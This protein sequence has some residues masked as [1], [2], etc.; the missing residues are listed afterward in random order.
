M[1]TTAERLIVIHIPARRINAAHSHRQPIHILELLL[2][3]I[4]FARIRDFAWQS[5]EAA[6]PAGELIGLVDFMHVSS[7][8][9]LFNL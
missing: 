4:D 9:Q 5:Q 6:K 1:T 7:S 2:Q 8:S 3:S